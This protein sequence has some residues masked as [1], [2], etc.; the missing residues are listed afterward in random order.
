[1]RHRTV[2]SFDQIGVD[3]EFAH[4]ML[5]HTL[6]LR[7]FNGHPVDGQAIVGMYLANALLTVM[8]T[9]ADGIGDLPGHAAALAKTEADVRRMGKRPRRHTATYSPY[10]ALAASA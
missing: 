5:G 3:P 7:C 4:G 8:S 10:E 1:M 6:W 2:V 9:V